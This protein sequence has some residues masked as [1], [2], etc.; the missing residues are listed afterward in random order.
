MKNTR[1]NLTEEAAD[2]LSSMIEDVKGQ[3]GVRVGASSLVSWIVSRYWGQF[4]ERE[5]GRIENAFLSRRDYLKG[6][7][8]AS[9]SDEE[10]ERALG[11]ALRKIARGRPGR[12]KEGT[13]HG[14]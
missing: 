13:G 8:S 5:K 2:A 10:A 3:P 4:F 9:A 12:G 11:E 7:L 14:S 6:L 1:I